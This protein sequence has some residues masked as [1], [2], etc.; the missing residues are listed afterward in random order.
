MGHF[1]ELSA[2]KVVAS[3]VD[4]NGTFKGHRRPSELLVDAAGAGAIRGALTEAESG[5]IFLVPAL[6]GGVQTIALPAPVVGVTYTFVMVD[7]AGQDM[8]VET[9][10]SATKILAVI[11]KGDGDNTAISQGYDKIGFDANAV[12]GTSFTITC[13]STTAA[14]AWLVTDVV[15]GL[16]ANTGSLNVA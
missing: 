12:I 14:N 13:I 9:D 3:S 16:A 7:T 8:N 1:D 11:P 10:V 6:T 4:M 15:D 5:S 2:K